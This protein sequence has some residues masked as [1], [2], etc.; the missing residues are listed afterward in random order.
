MR[1]SPLI[2]AAAV[3]V[4]LVWP[5]VR[6]FSD[7]VGPPDFSIATLSPQLRFSLPTCLA[8]LP[9]GRLLVGEKAGRVYMV[10]NGVKSAA[11]LW[12]PQ[13]EVLNSGDCGLV[14][15]AVDPNYFVNHFV[16]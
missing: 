12:D 10:T 15:I 4:C 3:L 2:S 6:A 9:D 1:R 14:G 8:F 16:Y 11:P 7:P 5:G 13:I